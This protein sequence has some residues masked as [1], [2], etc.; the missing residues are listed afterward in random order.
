MQYAI[1]H[2]PLYSYLQNTFNVAM[3]FLELNKKHTTHNKFSKLLWRCIP[4]RCQ[5]I[6]QCCAEVANRQ[7]SHIA[8]RSHTQTGRQRQ[9][10]HFLSVE[11]LQ[12]GS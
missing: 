5:M 4:R 8:V 12:L 9:L 11:I 7:P 3:L 2:G 6:E 1:K 10:T